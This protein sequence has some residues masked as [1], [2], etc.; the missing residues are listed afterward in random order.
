MTDA[1][2]LTGGTG[3]LGTEIA[4]QLVQQTGKTIYALVR[5]RDSAHAAMRLK[6]AWK[7]RDALYSAICGRIVPVPGDLEQADLGLTAD[8]A[9]CLLGNVH[10]IIHAAADVA[11]TRF[12]ET[13]MK[14]NRDG[15]K[16]LL[17]FAARIHAAGN[18]DRFVQISTAYVAGRETGTIFEDGRPAD[19][20]CGHYEESKAA[21]EALVRQFGLPYSIC[22]PGMI[23]GSSEDGH[24]R[25]F[26]TIYYV[27]KLIL[28][29]KLTVLPI[30][31]QQKL[32]VVPVDAVAQAAVKIAFAPE[33]A[34]KTFHLTI[35]AEQCP[36]AGE[37]VDY[38]REW[39]KENLNHSAAPVRFVS[40]PVLKAAGLSYN[41][42]T[43]AKKR[44]L[45]SNLLTLMPYFFDEHIFDRSNTDEIVGKYSG[46]WRDYAEKILSYACSKNFMQ[47]TERTVFQQAMV[48][49]ES[50]TNPIT[51][52]DVKADGI[53]ALSGREMN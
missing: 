8:A 11:V 47:Q 51:Y 10:T 1:I 44:S 2:L 22:R 23:I 31:R 49:R 16:N 39:A 21:A 14:A 7:D 5:A 28:T 46:N 12:R 29:G 18:L 42:K 48:R 6:A 34:G 15:T 30:S 37:L 13:L 45:A 41:R 43:E 36:T 38:L 9:A 19:T 4:A 35:P 24:I 3:F 33:A 20:F 52:F 25:S 17:T 53:T 32:N 27:M 40:V 50:R 26:N